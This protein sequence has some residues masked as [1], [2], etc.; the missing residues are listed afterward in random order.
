MQPYTEIIV[1]KLVLDY[2]DSYQSAKFIAV[3]VESFVTDHM[4]YIPML[5]HNLISSALRI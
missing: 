5:V 4:Q 2:P 3:P 1:T